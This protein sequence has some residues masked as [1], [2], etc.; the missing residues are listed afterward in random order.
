MVDASFISWAERRRFK[1]AD[2][3]YAHWSHAALIV[4]KD[5]ALVEAKTFGVARSPISEYHSDEYHVVRIGP[6]FT[7]D[8]R[9]KAVAYAEGQVG[10]PF[11]YLDMLGACLYLLFGWPLRRV[12]RNHEM[13][14]SLVVKALQKGGLLQGLDPS[15]TFPADLAR[16]F[17][18]RP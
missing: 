14:S 3:A 8:G 2:A 7:P 1:G 11:G 15:M 18:A 16:V 13:C 10:Q 17:D 6:Q 12:R 4:A 5:G 9:S